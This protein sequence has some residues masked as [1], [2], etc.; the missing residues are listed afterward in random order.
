M[1]YSFLK[2][3]VNSTNKELSFLLQLFERDAIFQINHRSCIIDQKLRGSIVKI[4]FSYN[5]VHSF[6]QIRQKE[7]F[8]DNILKMQN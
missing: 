7:Y 6:H 2:T 4:R 1:E 3:K 8:K 5:N